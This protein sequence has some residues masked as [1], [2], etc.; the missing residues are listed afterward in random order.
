MRPCDVFGLIVRTIGFVVLL[1]A[2]AFIVA[3][4]ARSVGVTF[5]TQQSVGVDV[6]F[7]VLYLI[8]GCGLYF[9]ANWVVA[10]TYGRDKPS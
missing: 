3:G 1:Y 6:V 9:G 5:A 7:G 2:L 4:I 8:L 10:A